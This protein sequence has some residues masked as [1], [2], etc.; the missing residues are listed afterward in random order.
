MA[1]NLCGEQE[2]RGEQANCPVSPCRK[3]PQAHS[4]QHPCISPRPRQERQ[5]QFFG[6][7][8]LISDDTTKGLTTQ[9]KTCLQLTPPLQ[10]QHYLVA[11][12][13]DQIQTPAIV[14]FIQKFCSLLHMSA[15]FMLSKEVSSPTASKKSSCS[16][17]LLPCLVHKQCVYWPTSGKVLLLKPVHNQSPHLNDHKAAP[18]GW[19]P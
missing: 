11:H 10:K 16:F 15:G 12:R 9:K 6:P 8:L 13:N 3:A 17:F 7:A 18:R 4:L 14:K 1:R 2:C 19:G 5:Q